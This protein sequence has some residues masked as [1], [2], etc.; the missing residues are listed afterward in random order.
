MKRARA[1]ILR[2][3]WELAGSNGETCEYLVPDV[4]KGSLSGEYFLVRIGDPSVNLL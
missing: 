1:D 4:L 2:S 3:W